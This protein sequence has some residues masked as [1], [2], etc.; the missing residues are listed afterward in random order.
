MVLRNVANRQ[1]K[2]PIGHINV[3]RQEKKIYDPLVVRLE[4]A[5]VIFINI[6]LWVPPHMLRS[7][8]VKRSICTNKDTSLM[9]LHQPTND[10]TLSIESLRTFER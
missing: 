8:D 9:W 1:P 7:D 6:L 3:A 2:L 5:Y 4:K 10:T